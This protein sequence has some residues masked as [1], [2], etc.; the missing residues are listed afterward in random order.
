MCGQARRQ[1]RAQGGRQR[2]VAL[3]RDAA[4]PLAWKGCQAGVGKGWGGTPATV[5]GDKMAA[6]GVDIKHPRGWRGRHMRGL[7]WGAAQ[8]LLTDF[9]LASQK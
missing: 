3:G 8:S 4:G 1:A 2:D 7:G 9:G 5:E 6:F